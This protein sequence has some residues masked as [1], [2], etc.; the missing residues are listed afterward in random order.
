[1]FDTSE[2]HLEIDNAGIIA[3]LHDRLGGKGYLAEGQAAPLLQVRV[4]GAF[5]SPSRADVDAGVVRLTYSDAGVQA[6]ITVT[7]KSSHLVLELT[8]AE[9]LER[10]D[11]VQWGPIPTTITETVGEIIG[12]VRDGDYA[13]GI[14]ALNTKTIG[15]P[16]FNT[17]GSNTATGMGH[18]GVTALRTD[19][20]STLQAFSLDRSRPREVR[21]FYDRLPGVPV[22][23]IP[24]E[25]VMGSKIALFGCRGED[26][27]QRIGEIEVAEGLPHPEIDGVWAK[28]SREPG[29]PYLIGWVGENSVDELIGYALRAGFSC[30]YVYGPFETWGHFKLDP[31][32]FPN[33]IEGMKAVV[34]KAEEAGLRVGVHTLSNFLTP[35]DAYITPV[36]DP[37]LAAAGSSPL[38]ADAGAGDKTLSVAA[39]DCFDNDDF[40]C[41]RTVRIGTELIRYGQVSKEEPWTLSN[42]QRGAFGTAAAAHA[43]GDE[44]VKLMDHPYKVF[45]PNF[46]MQQ[47]VAMNLVN[48]FNETG[49]SQLDFDGHEGCQAS[50]Q[51]EYGIEAFAKTFHDNIDHLVFN[52]SSN[53]HH[54]YWHIC[55]QVNWGEPW[56]GGFRN[57]QT[58]YRFEH[59]ALYERNFLPN[60]LGWYNME[61]T[62]TLADME[63]LM[64]RAAG[65]DAGF[66]LVAHEDNI[67]ANPQSDVILDTIG[68]WENA[69]QAGV[70]TPEQREILK[71]PTREFHF[72]KRDEGGCNLY[73]FHTSA[74]FTHESRM[75]QP[76][77][78]TT[79][80]WDVTNRDEAQPLQFFLEVTGE[81][82]SIRNPVI[83]IDNYARIEIPAEI[84]AG[85]S[86]LCDGTKTLRLYGPTGKYVASIELDDDVPE[87]DGGAHQA[88]FDCKFD[89]SPGPKV[90]VTF[91]TR[92]SP[93]VLGQ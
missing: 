90:A 10:I 46:E 77:E 30:L 38:T 71:D 81:A 54:F 6:I 83:E 85:H 19:W 16:W 14:Q 76:G 48:F 13:V 12:V 20:G 31:K 88:E 43:A 68:L 61:A 55:T 11:A 42:C 27:L 56:L 2:F 67:R 23:P 9:P 32:L 33:G 28:L 91:K 21:A 18:R 29:R 45:F 65:Y 92:G 57:S 35:N 4:D 51:G 74:A 15:G 58:A 22:P 3:S 73:P 52:G 87:M 93:I 66:A 79:V 5:H 24:G 25:T 8:E 62:T 34:E 36:P 78:P 41:L 84:E 70:F 49:V 50:G 80:Q 82:G 63:W 64:A 40:N 39:P 69:R 59:Q 75:L 53:S 72:E 47:E 86:L 1:M 44:V 26:A 17:E 60:M 7:A 89:G 37:R